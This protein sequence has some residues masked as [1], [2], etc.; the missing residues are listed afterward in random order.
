MRSP[1]CD[2]FGIETPIFAFSHCRDVVVEASRAGGLGV[3]G[4]AHFSPEELER[5]LRWIDDH[6]EGKPYG[7]DLLMPSSYAKVDLDT[8]D[9]SKLIP[10]GHRAFMAEMLAR[11]GVPPLPEGMAE[12]IRKVTLRRF[13]VS[14][15]QHEEELEIAFRHPFKLLVAA[16]GRP[17]EKVVRRAR[18]KGIRLASLVGTP[19]HALRQKEAGVDL[20]V[21]QGTE[22]GGHTGAIST[23]VLTP[24]IVDLVAPTP[25]LAAGG[26]ATGRQMAAAMALGA[27][28][29]WCGSVWLTTKESDAPPEVKR[30]ILAAQS[31]DAV[32]TRSYSGK[33]SRVLRSGWTD[34]WSAS[35]SPD[36]LQIPLQSLLTKEAMARVTRAGADAMA[37]YPAG[38]VIGMMTSESTVRQVFQDMLTE[39]AEAMERM[40]ALSAD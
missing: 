28:G 38:Q 7:L 36:P 16:L 39:F 9:T 32:I 3:L 24:Q 40:N 4:T 35:G 25:V 29:V 30:R 11:N 37:S 19:E 23:M 10:E 27:A 26:I 8:Q 34:A 1:A 13:S 2:L 22:A 5:E 20:I 33:P 31:K 18:E 21:A 6:V 15:E 14:P 17:N 12:E